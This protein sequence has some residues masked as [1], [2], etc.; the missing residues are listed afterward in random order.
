[1][2]LYF[3]ER[4]EILMDL[5]DKHHGYKSEQIKPLIKF[6]R[7]IS[8]K[9]NIVVYKNQKLYIIKEDNK[10]KYYLNFIFEND[11]SALLKTYFQ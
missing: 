2:E 9:N 7:T 6:W 1:M 5:F 4:C 3:S 11:L 8:V 10:K